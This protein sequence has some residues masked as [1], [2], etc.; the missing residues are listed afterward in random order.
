MFPL[1][2]KGKGIKDLIMHFNLGEDPFLAFP[3]TGTERS[4]LCCQN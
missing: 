1:E 2:D 3:V 4:N